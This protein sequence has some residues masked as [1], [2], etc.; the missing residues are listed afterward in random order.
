M[1]NLF[2]LKGAGGTLSIQTTTPW[3]SGE[4]LLPL[5]KNRLPVFPACRKRRLKGGHPVGV[6]GL[7]LHG[8]QD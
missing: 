5:R 4:G 2:P 1:L 8:T 7:F 3:V 6:Q